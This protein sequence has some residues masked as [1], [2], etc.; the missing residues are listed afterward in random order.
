MVRVEENYLFRVEQKNWL[1]SKTN[2][3]EVIQ[4]INFW[5]IINRYGRAYHC[6]PHNNFRK[7]DSLSYYMSSEKK[8]CYSKIVYG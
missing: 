7:T 2:Y 4:I 1:Y 3:E 8:P 5:Q 6:R